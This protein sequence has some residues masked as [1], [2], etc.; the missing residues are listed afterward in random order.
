MGIE[1]E[2]VDE[3]GADAEP[4]VLQAASCASKPEI[5]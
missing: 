2:F 1:C 4:E 3:A 5:S